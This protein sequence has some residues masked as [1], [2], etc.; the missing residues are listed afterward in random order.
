M[1]ESVYWINMNA[2]IE[3]TVQQYFTYLEYQCTLPCETALLYDI[4]CKPG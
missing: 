4:P 2:D 3:Q 1:R